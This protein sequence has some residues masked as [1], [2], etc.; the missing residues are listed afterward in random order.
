MTFGQFILAYLAVLYAAMCVGVVLAIMYAV[1]LTPFLF[2]YI[3]IRGFIGV[4][5][6]VVRKIGR[7]V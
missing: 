2:A 3:V 4:V 7:M 1:C 6:W 5:V